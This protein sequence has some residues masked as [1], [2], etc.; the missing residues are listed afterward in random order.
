MVPLQ[1][2][3]ALRSSSSQAATKTPRQH[4]GPLARRRCPPQISISYSFPAAQRP[5][6][7]KPAHLLPFAVFVLVHS[8]CRAEGSS[9]C[10]E[11][12][13]RQLLVMRA[14]E[15]RPLGFFPMDRNQRTRRDHTDPSKV[16]YEPTIIFHLARI[17]LCRCIRVSLVIFHF[18]KAAVVAPE[19]FRGVLRKVRAGKRWAGSGFGMFVRTSTWRTR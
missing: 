10:F 12:H 8:V 13:N 17:L 4:A 5:S 6:L 9:L 15:M 18:F 11:Q 7:R 1:P 16:E 14:S 3:R 19:V 2:G